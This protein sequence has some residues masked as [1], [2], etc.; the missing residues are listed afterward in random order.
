MAN[1]DGELTWIEKSTGAMRLG[2]PVRTHVSRPD[3]IIRVPT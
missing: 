2:V 3:Q 1:F